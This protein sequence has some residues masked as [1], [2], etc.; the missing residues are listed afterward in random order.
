MAKSI[1]AYKVAF[2]PASFPKGVYYSAIEREFGLKYELNKETKPRKNCNQFICVF[3]TLAS[4]KNFLNALF[5]KCERKFFVIL[6][7]K[8]NNPSNEAKLLNGKNISSLL[9]NSFF[10]SSCTPVKKMLANLFFI[11]Y[12][13]DFL[14]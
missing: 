10:C 9:K 5:C 3:K 1:I 2:K 4:A 7:V 14:V 13:V 11:N 12:F 6:K 8:A